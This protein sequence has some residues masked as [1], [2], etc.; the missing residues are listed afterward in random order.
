MVPAGQHHAGTGTGQPHQGVVEQPHDVD[1]RQ[2]AVVHVA[3][4]EDNVDG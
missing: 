1:P 2:C 3:G 4:D